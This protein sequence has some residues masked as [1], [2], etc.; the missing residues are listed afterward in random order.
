MIHFC[1]HMPD[2]TTPESTFLRGYFQTQYADMQELSTVYTSLERWPSQ[3]IYEETQGEIQ[4]FFLTVVVFNYYI[5]QLSRESP[6]IKRQYAAWDETINTVDKLNALC[7]R[8]M[9]IMQSQTKPL[10]PKTFATIAHHVSERF[11]HI[12]QSK[13][14]MELHSLVQIVK[15]AHAVFSFFATKD[16][17]KSPYMMPE[18]MTHLRLCQELMVSSPLIQEL[19]RLCIMDDMSNP[20]ASPIKHKRPEAAPEPL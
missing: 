20:T 17:E 10:P 2:T 9:R 7:L 16:P 15:E 8:A 19:F 13:T 14:V 5:F 11:H 3:T 12:I 18:L 4:R 6:S 1:N